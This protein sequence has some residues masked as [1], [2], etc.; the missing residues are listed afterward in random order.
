M[1][2]TQSQRRLGK[3]VSILG[4][5]LDNLT[6]TE[7]KKRL[8]DILIHRRRSQIVT[9]NP[10]FLL[11]AEKH[12][13]FYAV[14]R[15]AALSIPD[16][17]G[18]K[19]AAWVKGVNLKRFT[20]V[21]VVSGLLQF[22][23]HKGLRVAVL[24]WKEGLSSD[25]DIRSALAVKYPKL[26]FYIDSLSREEVYNFS[27]LKKFKPDILFTALGAPWQDIFI[28]RHRR[29]LPSLRL[30]MGV[31]GSFDY[32]TKR[33][34]RPPRIFRFLGFE[35]LW[36]LL[37]KPKTRWKRIW[38]SVV[39]FPWKI[40]NWEFRRFRYRPN[41]V[42]LVINRF[43]ETLILNARG[44]GDY[45]GLPQGGVDGGEDKEQ[46]VRREIFEE[47]GLRD[48]SLEARFDNIYRYEWSKPYDYKGYKGQQQS[49]FILRYHGERQAVAINPFE[50]KAFR[51]VKIENLLSATSPVHK[52]QYQLFLQKY[53][54]K[55]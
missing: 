9:P 48:L 44:K 14:L 29:D 55:K 35:W 10:E 54:E 41:V 32:I 39:V 26:Q 11:L 16:G 20:G 6:T 23:A 49:L 33:M 8:I 2:R 42:G 51:W 5:S 3:K 28:Y 19:F 43:G 13:E 40:I 45:W 37:M 34:P 47:T 17:I 7:L 15:D 4:V 38:Q 1:N 25:D 18:L 53:Y 46:A 21:S 24:N 31:G 12:Q 27:S 30:G 36:R 50:H 22:A 52:K